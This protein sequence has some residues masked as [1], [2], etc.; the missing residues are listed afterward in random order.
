VNTCSFTRSNKQYSSSQLNMTSNE[1]MPFSF[2][3]LRL[4][5]II[6]S[7]YTIFI[8]FSFYGFC[9]CSY[10][11]RSIT[12]L[13]HIPLFCLFLFPLSH[14]NAVLI[15]WYV[16]NINSL[17]HFNNYLFPS[18]FDNVDEQQKRYLAYCSTFT[19]NTY[20]GCN[21]KWNLS[22]MSNLSYYSPH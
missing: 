15:S 16:N 6:Q 8:Y 9:R 2:K 18:V 5:V 12:S 20:M 13:Q 17:I 1:Y 3:Y 21:T 22:F 4:V 14:S 11:F 7:Y 19:T 10:F